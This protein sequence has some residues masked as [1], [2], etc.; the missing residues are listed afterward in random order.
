MINNRV[1][2]SLIDNSNTNLIYNNFFNNTLLNVF[3]EGTNSWNISKTPGTNIVGGPFLGGNFWSDYAGAD[4]DGDGLGDT[5]L[6]YNNS[7][8]IHNGGDFLPLVFVPQPQACVGSLSSGMVS[9]WPGDSDASDIQNGNDGTLVNGATF[10]TGKVDQ[11]FSFDG[12]DD[13]V[14]VGNGANL[15]IGTGDFAVEFWVLVNDSQWNSILYKY[16]T[17]T[18]SSNKHYRIHAA[19]TMIEGEFPFECHLRHYHQATS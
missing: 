13:Y 1:G 14:D 19:Q 8:N 17:G 18:S 3:D 15:N 7:G 4:L 5:Q 9:W 11:A 6:P 2:I 12:V 10:A 16:S